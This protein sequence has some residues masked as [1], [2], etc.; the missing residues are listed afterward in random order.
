MKD[1]IADKLMLIYAFTAL[2]GMLYLFR[3]SPNMSNGC[4]LSVAMVVGAIC[5]MAQGKRP[6]DQ[7]NNISDS[8][9]SIDPKDPNAK[10]TT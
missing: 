1:H 6:Q 2:G 8:S 10:P 5:N 9:I 7:Q 4:M 3:D